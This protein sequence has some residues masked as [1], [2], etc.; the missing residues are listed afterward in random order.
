LVDCRRFVFELCI[1][2]AD[3]FV[4]ANVDPTAGTSIALLETSD[5]T[6]YKLPFHRTIVVC[7]QNI[8]LAFEV[9]FQTFFVFDCCDLVDWWFLVT[10]HQEEVGIGVRSYYH[11]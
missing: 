11:W 1:V 9:N 5:R 10:I 6:W 2:C 7:L 3:S 4:C 8:I